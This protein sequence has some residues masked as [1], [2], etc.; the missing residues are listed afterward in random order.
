[1]NEID[2]IQAVLRRHGHD[3]T[4]LMQILRETQEALGWLSPATL[5]AIAA[6]IGWPRAEVEGTASFYRFF[7]TRPLG[8]YRVLWSDDITDRLLGSRDLMQSMCR[9]LWVERGRVSKDGL[10]SVDATSC[11]GLCDQGPAVLVN[12]RA[13]G[14]MTAE[15]VAR[16]AELIRGEVPLADW[17]ADWFVITDNIRR[18]D[19]LLANTLAPGQALAAARARGPEATLAEIRATL[20]RGRGGAGFV[21]ADKWQAC[22]YAP[23]PARAGVLSICAANTAI[24]PNR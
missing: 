13:I 14:R 24:C 18:R 6:G 21:T 20:L 10:V 7:H 19:M 1:M 22:R 11:T 4:R 9:Q 17:P 8:R 23:G 15:R 2:A 5:S 16:M 12:Y 3:G